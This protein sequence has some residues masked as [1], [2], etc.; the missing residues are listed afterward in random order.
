MNLVPGGDGAGFDNIHNL[1]TLAGIPSLLPLYNSNVL[2]FE[3]QVPASV[4]EACGTGDRTTK[5]QTSWNLYGGNNFLERQVL[6]SFQGKATIT[7]LLNALGHHVIKA[8]V[9]GSLSYYEHLKTYGGGAWYFDF[10]PGGVAPGNSLGVQEARRFGVL[11]DIDTTAG[12]GILTAKSKSVIIGGFVQDSWS[13]LDKVTLNV[14]LRWDGQYLYDKDGLLAMKL[15]N[16]W[17]PRIGF[18]WDPTQQGRSKIFANYGRYYEAIPLDI[19]DRALSGESLVIA[20]HD[21]DPRVVGVAGCDLATANRGSN[22]ARPNV[23]WRNL[24][25]DKTAVDP[26]LQPTTNDE[27]VA[28][29][30]YEVF[31]SARVGVSYTYRNLVRTIEDIHVYLAAIAYILKLARRVP[32]TTAQLAA[33]AASLAALADEPPLAP[34]THVALEGALQLGRQAIE[35]LDLGAAPPGCDDERARFERDRPLLR[36]AEKVRGLRFASA[37]EALGI[38]MAE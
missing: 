19:A 23:K 27:V 2:D 34:S 14:G 11:S 25:V 22:I 21:C 6:D 17:S 18:V 24:A 5:C 3:D 8:G 30:E 15:G 37:C 36:V 10:G 1:N 28:G 29:G 9:D 38:R 32:G 26:N 31:P 7:Y 33:V 16:E 13:I 35:A 4:R 20:N 12:N